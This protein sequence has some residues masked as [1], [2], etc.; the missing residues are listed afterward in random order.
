ML[1]YHKDSQIPIKFEMPSES[2]SN[3]DEE[4]ANNINSLKAQFNKMNEEIMNMKDMQT[5]FVSAN[6]LD[7]LL[8][9]ADSKEQLSDMKSI[10]DYEQMN[11]QELKDLSQR[12]NDLSNAIKCIKHQLLVTMKLLHQNNTEKSEQ[13]DTHVA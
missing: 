9:N 2:N 1:I 10:Q 3:I 8:G 11:S 4:Y 12:T 5:Q 7:L 13:I 6:T